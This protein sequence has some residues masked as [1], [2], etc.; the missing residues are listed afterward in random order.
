LLGERATR[1][2]E[3]RE[4]QRRVR[5]IRRR[6]L[7]VAVAA[8]GVVAISGTA[9]AGHQTSGVKSYTGCLVSG[10]GVMIK[11]KEGNSPRSA[12]T[13][14]QVEAHFSGGDITKISVGS[15]LTTVPAD[16]ANGEV[17]ILLDASHTLPQGCD[18]GEVAKWETSVVPDR[19]IC[20][21]DNDTTYTAG[22]GLDLSQA[23]AFE[24][25]PDYRVKNT[26]DCSSGQFATGFNDDG[27]IQCQAPGSSG[28]EAWQ[29]LGAQ[30]VPLPKGQGVDLVIMPLPPG[31][32]LVTGVA[33]LRD[34]G[35]D[36]RDEEVSVRC[37][38]RNGAFAVLPVPESQ[39]DIGEE[40]GLDGPAG[41]ATVHGAVTLASADS[42]RFTC[43]ST[44]G[45]SDPDQ[46]LSS[47]LTAIKVGALHTP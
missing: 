42:V 14:G 2:E 22:T 27:G 21:D 16:G 47:T 15:G 31:T 1:D 24:I 8:L 7:A 4:M 29:K 43:L 25:Q 6:V 45:D 13:G 9:L 33:T 18:D 35:G 44:D 26:P 46:A 11:I 30:V 39:V 37:S 28:V 38:L 34:G 12:C 17:R 36:F 32:Y 10:D 20:R 5:W 23:G 41:N 40:L 3:E 19:W